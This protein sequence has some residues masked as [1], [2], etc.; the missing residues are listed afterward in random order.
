MSHPIILTAMKS[1]F[2]CLGGN[3]NVLLS[4][5][6]P[7]RATA[8]AERAIADGAC[9][10]VSFGVVGGLVDTVKAGDVVL[11]DVIVTSDGRRL[12]TDARWRASFAEVANG[13]LGGVMVGSDFGIST[14]EAK[15]Q[16]AEQS[17]AVAVDMESHAI[18][19]A[20][21]KAGLPFL[22]IRAVA[23]GPSRSLPKWMSKHIDRD[24]TVRE[25]AIA[26]EALMR[27]WELP[28]MVGLAMD[29][30]RAHRALRD[31]AFVAGPG[32]GFPD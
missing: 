6:G 15:Q 10:L 25:G 20:A 7:E 5:I 17:G 23:D 9:G 29:S 13:L 27:F 8:A 21:D 1:E 24:G 28:G 2:A 16:L 12:A 30:H 19:L 14:P 22:V 26:L 4:G 3:D 11:A 18:A 31:L 32:F